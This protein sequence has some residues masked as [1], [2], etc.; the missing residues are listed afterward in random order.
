M[1]LLSYYANI[2]LISEEIP[3]ILTLVLEWA[4]TK[5]EPFPPNVSWNCV[6]EPGLIILFKN[7][8]P[9][10]IWWTISYDP[11]LAD[12]LDLLSLDLKYLIY[13]VST[14]ILNL[15]CFSMR[16]RIS[17]C[18]LFSALICN[19]QT[20]PHS[21]TIWHDG[22]IEVWKDWGQVSRS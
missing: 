5:W 11:P 9:A 17:T 2:T 18:C 22:Q 15:H 10:S 3:W 4:I 8:S 7:I 20:Y 12:N 14:I 19:S 16:I 6:A 13:T 1:L 21:F